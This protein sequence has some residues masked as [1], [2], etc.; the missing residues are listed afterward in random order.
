MRARTVVLVAVV[1]VAS[2]ALPRIARAADVV[3]AEPP[4]AAR[5]A[6][7]FYP[8]SPRPFA[9][10]AGVGLLVDVLPSR[11][12]ESEQRQVPMLTGA[13]R[14]GLPVGFAADVRARAIVIQNQLELGVSWGH[15]WSWLS[16]SIQNH[17]GPW[18]GTVGVEGF[19]T[20]AWGM[21]E[22][23]GVSVGVAWRDVRFSL[24][25]EAIVTFAQ[26]TT[27]GDT[28]KTTRDGTAFAGTATTL[29]VETLLE[30]GGVPWFGVGLLWTRPDYQAW[31]AFSDE[32]ARVLYPR[33]VVGYA[34]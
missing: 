16:V 25:E 23:P 12:V 21:L 5:P 33:F 26:R 6:L 8:T 2:C 1:T 7:L 17:I 13:V 15:E 19:D 34:F 3:E 30:G 20:S 28:T 24:L 4:P 29:T 32:R 31:L 18:F 27:L 9:W 14:L 22:T 11:I 10:R